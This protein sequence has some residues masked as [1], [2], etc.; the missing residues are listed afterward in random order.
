MALYAALQPGISPGAFP[1]HEQPSRDA[2]NARSRFDVG[3][4]DDAPC[5]LGHEPRN[6]AGDDDP[7][8]QAP[9]QQHI[10][11]HVPPIRVLWRKSDLS[12]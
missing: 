7:M 8:L 11:N 9:L 3:A 4:R 2:Q 12:N 10:I 5:P 6:D 1:A